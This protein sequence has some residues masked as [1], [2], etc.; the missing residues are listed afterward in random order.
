MAMV[1]YRK[2]LV[3]KVRK[4]QRRIMETPISEKARKD[5][6]Y[7]QVDR[8]SILTLTETK[9]QNNGQGTQPEL[10]RHQSLYMT[11]QIRQV[12]HTKMSK[13]F[14]NKANNDAMTRWASNCKYDLPNTRVFPHFLTVRD[15]YDSHLFPLSSHMLIFLAVY[16]GGYFWNVR[17]LY[18]ISVCGCACAKGSDGV[19]TQKKKR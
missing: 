17:F 9:G 4:G 8:H 11:W 16:F 15:A 7:R 3:G 18:L 5:T 10:T 1:S 13:V 2:Q 14:L 6:E 12:F 19:Q